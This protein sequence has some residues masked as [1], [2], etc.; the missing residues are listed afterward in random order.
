M[1]FGNKFLHLSVPFYIIAVVKTPQK[2]SRDILP[3]YGISP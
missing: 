3:D 1:V 2:K